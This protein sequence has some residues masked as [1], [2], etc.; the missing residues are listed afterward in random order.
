MWIWDGHSQSVT[1]DIRDFSLLVYLD[2]DS[3]FASLGGNEL[4]PE[5]W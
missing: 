1:V 4:S 2:I 5:N 3:Y